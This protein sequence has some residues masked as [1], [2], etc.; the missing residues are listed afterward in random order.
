MLTKSERDKIQ[1]DTKAYWGKVDAENAVKKSNQICIWEE[2][3]VTKI[4]RPEDNLPANSSSSVTWWLK[5][6]VPFL[7]S[8]GYDVM[9]FD[10]M[11][12]P[13]FDSKNPIR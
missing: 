9:V 1:A 10:Y 12:R 8:Q 3:T 11:H 2:K 7:L 5:N 13:L 4:R 6:E